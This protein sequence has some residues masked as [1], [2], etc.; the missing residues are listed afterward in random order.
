MIAECRCLTTSPFDLIS[1]RL[2]NQISRL[3]R[4]STIDSTRSQAWSCLSALDAAAHQVESQESANGTIPSPTAPEKVD[5]WKAVELIEYSF[6]AVASAIPSMADHF[7]LN[8]TSDRRVTVVDVA[9]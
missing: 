5:L 9:A 1:F 4:S 2:S 8:A 6:P 3:S 7:D